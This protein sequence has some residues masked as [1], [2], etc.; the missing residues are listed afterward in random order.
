MP[1]DDNADRAPNQTQQATRHAMWAGEIMQTQFQQEPFIVSNGLLPVGG[2]MFVGGP[3]K[4]YKSFTA[5]SMAVDLATGSRVFDASITRAR[6]T[7][8]RFNVSK[9]YK[10]L[11]LEQEIGLADDKERL[12]PI[13]ECLSA[14]ER[15]LLNNNLAIYAQD[16][17]MRLDDGSTMNGRIRTIIGEVNPDVLI[18]DPLIEFHT[19]D[20]N[21][22]R[23]MGLIMRQVNVLKQLFAL[24]GVIIVHHTGKPPA[25]GGIAMG[26]DAADYLRGS[27]VLYG[28][29]D[30]C[31]MLSRGADD[32]VNM[33][34]TLRRAKPM[35]PMKAKI[36]WISG[37]VRCI[38]W[39]SGGRHGGGAQVGNQNAKKAEA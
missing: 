8:T 16:H 38:G 5:L 17:E 23:D 28:K 32:T 33:S 21:S 1:Q 18:I 36:D 12:R 13:Y 11:Y 20:E 37:R 29:A 10:V 39:H 15:G 24:K 14:H 3:P 4:T 27:S 2:L 9:P 6:D 30:T 25:D 7:E 19:Q 22:T 35:Q 26:R 31:L 34:F